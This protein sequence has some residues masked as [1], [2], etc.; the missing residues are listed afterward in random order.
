VNSG[1]LKE[2]GGSTK[3]LKGE[4]GTHG[5]T[6]S[7][8][9]EKPLS[10]TKKRKTLKGG[11]HQ[12]QTSQNRKNH[13]ELGEGVPICKGGNCT[14]KRVET[15]VTVDLSRGNKSRGKNLLYEGASEHGMV[16]GELEDGRSEGGRAGNVGAKHS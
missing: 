11:V 14:E 13:G 8:S 5:R 9:S 4:L 15:H 16:E 6:A 1:E 12:K 10:G 2:K 3:E 7:R